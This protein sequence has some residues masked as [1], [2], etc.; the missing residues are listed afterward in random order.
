[1][2]AARRM[3]RSSRSGLVLLGLIVALS[4]SFDVARDRNA[5]DQATRGLRNQLALLHGAPIAPGA[6]DLPDDG[7]GTAYNLEVEPVSMSD[8]TKQPLLGLYR[9][10]ITAQWKDSGRIEKRSISELV[11]RP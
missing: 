11:Y 7:S 10:T 9:A 5:A 6:R 4:K 1:M 2:N 3:R 8:Q